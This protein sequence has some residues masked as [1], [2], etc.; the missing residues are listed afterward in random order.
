MIYVNRLWL[1][2]RVASSPVMK[3]L[4]S[5]TKVTSFSLS[6]VESWV[7]E[8]NKPRSH[9]NTFTVEVIGRDAYRVAQEA[10]LG[11]WVT[12]DG[13][14]RSQELKGAHVTVVRTFSI[15]IWAEVRDG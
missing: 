9:T 6:V 2:G 11:F 14:L 5:R 10:K 13:Y 3:D 8:E 4:S 12:L 15:N 1:Q 7:N